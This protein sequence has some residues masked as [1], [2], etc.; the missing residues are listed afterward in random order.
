MSFTERILYHVRVCQFLLALN[1][2]QYFLLIFV[3]FVCFTLPARSFLR[4]FPILSQRY[5]AV[6]PALPIYTEKKDREL[7]PYPLQKYLLSLRRPS[8]RSLRPRL[9][10]FILNTI[11]KNSGVL[12]QPQPTQMQAPSLLPLLRRETCL[13]SAQPCSQ[14]PAARLRPLRHRLAVLPAARCP[15]SRIPG[16]LPASCPGLRRAA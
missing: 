7:C 8:G 11:L 4:H 13:R 14:W 9:Y 15:A 5:P 16:H 12:P 6:Y 3:H 2:S 10:L 1:Y